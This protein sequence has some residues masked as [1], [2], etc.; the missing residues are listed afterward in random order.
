M[1][2]T[3]LRTKLQRP[4]L[5]THV[6]ARSHLIQQLN[7]NLDWGHRLTLV[8]APAGFGKS[9]L[10]ALWATEAKRPFAWLSLETR[11]N[12]LKRFAT[13]FVAALQT[14]V[15]AIEETAVSLLESPHFNSLNHLFTLLLNELTQLR[16]PVG[17]IL[18]DY[19]LI[20]NPDIHAALDFLIANAPLTST[21]AC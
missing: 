8:M 7:Q 3:I 17:L 11:D 5:Q 16:Q 19:H 20:T 2:S 6:V 14:V 10:G 4:S 15:P 12:E 21:L 9:T 1:L 18:D 13:Y